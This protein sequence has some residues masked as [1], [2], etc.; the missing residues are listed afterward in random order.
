MPYLEYI[1]CEMVSLCLVVSRCVLNRNLKYSE[2]YEDRKKLPIVPKAGF[3][4][5]QRH[6]RCVAL[7][8]ANELVAW[9]RKSQS[10]RSRQF[11]RLENFL[12]VADN[13]CP[14]L[15]SYKYKAVNLLIAAPQSREVYGKL[16]Y[17]VPSRQNLVLAC[18]R[19]AHVRG[20]THVWGSE[21][22]DKLLSR[23]LKASI[24]RR[25]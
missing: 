13:V 12:D 5:N 23:N 17:S 6:H 7:G 9:Q 1:G 15:I 18:G 8:A 14:L 4:V 3:F 19:A 22:R 2:E 25:H 16:E 24:N 11:Y 20:C 10:E 21:R